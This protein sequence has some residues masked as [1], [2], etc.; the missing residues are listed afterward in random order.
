MLIILVDTKLRFLNCYQN[1]KSTVFDY[2]GL[3]IVFEDE[4]A[5]DDGDDE[6]DGDVEHTDGTHIYSILSPRVTQHFVAPEI[7]I[8]MEPVDGNFQCYDGNLHSCGQS[9]ARSPITGTNSMY[10]LRYRMPSYR[11]DYYSV[12]NSYFTLTPGS[13]SIQFHLFEVPYGAGIHLK[14]VFQYLARKF[15]YFTFW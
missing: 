5:D 7:N 12:Q 3:E 13:Q 9:T 4:D 10:H 1:Q 8:L 6:D 15:F 14:K 11:K 2:N